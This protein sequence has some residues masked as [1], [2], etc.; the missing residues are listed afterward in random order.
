MMRAPTFHKG[1]TAVEMMVVVLILA[2]LGAFAAP[3]MMQ[4]IR[5]Q[6]VRSAAY[7]IFAD[8]TYARS[9]AINRGHD[10]LVTSSGGNTDWVGGWALRDTVTGEV[11][12]QQG[13]L[14]TGITFAADFGSITYD[15]NGRVGNSNVRFN[16]APVESAPDDQKRC[17]RVTP[18][19]RPNSING[20]CP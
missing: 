13:S 1:F 10:I 11:L 17:V 3:S 2:I 14:S 18:S 6:K 4:L 19:G 9:E 16:I 20:V 8:L 15:R 7:D 12:R 5:T